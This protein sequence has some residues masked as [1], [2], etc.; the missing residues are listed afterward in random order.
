M[1]QLIRATMIPL[2][3]VHFSQPGRL[4]SSDSIEVERRKAIARHN[5]MRTN[6]AS[7]VGA[8]DYR[9]IQQINQA[10]R[11]KKTAA[12]TTDSSQSAALKL[13]NGQTAQSVSN[14]TFSP[15]AAVS[16]S[17]SVSTEQSVETA[18]TYP[19][20]SISGVSETEAAYTVQRGAFELRVAKGELSYLPPLDM[21]IIVQYPGVEFEYLGDFNYVPARDEES[22]GAGLNQ[23]I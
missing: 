12:P 1:G 9:Y 2:K 6:Y 11:S 19:S 22:G 4:V 18:Y 5:A 14:Q 23:S 15:A 17:S 16:S 8:N 13:T 3:T 20:A 21:T 10:F 7:T